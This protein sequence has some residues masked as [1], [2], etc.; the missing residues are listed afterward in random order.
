MYVLWFVLYVALCIAL[1]R[2]LARAVTQA[3]WARWAMIAALLPLFLLLP[4]ADEIVGYFQ[5]ERLC[6]Q[7]REVRVHATMPVGEDL[8]TPQGKW[9]MDLAEGD[10]DERFRIRFRAQQALD[11][12]IRAENRALPATGSAIEIRGRE[13]RMFDVRTSR[14]L[15]EWRQFST[16]G[17]WLS[18]HFEKPLLVRPQCV[19]R[20]VQERTVAQTVLPFAGTSR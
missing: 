4:L 5:F 20:A 1:A 11:T 12:H 8:Y 18:R 19:P 2:W 9:R 7:A 6:E 10:A 13:I 14:L 16:S 15:A 17:G 3:A